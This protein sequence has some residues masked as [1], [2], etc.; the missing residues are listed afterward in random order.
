MNDILPN[1]MVSAFIIAID[2]WSLNKS[3]KIDKDYFMNIYSAKLSKQNRI[4]EEQ[5]IAIGSVILENNNIVPEG[6]FLV[7]AADRLRSCRL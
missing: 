5:I 4:S 7:L 3:G 6:N 1:Y 2:M